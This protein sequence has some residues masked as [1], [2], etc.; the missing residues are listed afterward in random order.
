[1]SG[2]GGLTL[3]DGASG[4]WGVQSPPCDGL[5]GGSRSVRAGGE[6]V[7]EALHPASIDAEVA[8]AGPARAADV[9]AAAI[10]S[11]FDRHVDVVPKQPG[12]AVH[13]CG[14]HRV[15]AD[16]QADGP[17]RAEGLPGAIKERVRR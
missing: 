13:G 9:K 7:E 12:D 6:A 14:A 4:T 3:T 15:G 11:G 5:P 17:E 16:L 1:M 8:V 10:R 2:G